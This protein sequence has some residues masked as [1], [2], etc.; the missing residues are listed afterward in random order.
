MVDLEKWCRPELMSDLFHEVEK[1]N[2][3]VVKVTL[4]P[5]VRAFLTQIQL[6]SGASLMDEDG[7]YLWGAEVVDAEDAFVVVEGEHGAVARAWM[8]DRGPRIESPGSF[9]A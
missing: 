1:C 3:R 4:P 8:T 2:Q 7:S 5:L 9:D 6:K